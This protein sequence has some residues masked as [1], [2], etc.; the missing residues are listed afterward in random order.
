MRQQNSRM[1]IKHFEYENDTCFTP[2]AKV[3]HDCSET[4]PLD[5]IRVQNP[6]STGEQHSQ[7]LPPFSSASAPPER[8]AGARQYRYLWV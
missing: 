6:S 7:A 5:T 2:F 8:F 4:H 1:R 3:A